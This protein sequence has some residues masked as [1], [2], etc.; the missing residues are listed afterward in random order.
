MDPVPVSL[1]SREVEVRGEVLAV[2][3]AAVSVDESAMVE[4]SAVLVENAKPNRPSVSAALDTFRVS[5]VSYSLSEE[6]EVAVSIR[7]DNIDS[8]EQST[9]LVRFSDLLQFSRTLRDKMTEHFSITAGSDT[10]IGGVRNNRL[11]R[12]EGSFRVVQQI[13]TAELGSRI[14]E[15]AFWSQS[16]A[17]MNEYLTH[18]VDLDPS[19]TLF[20]EVRDFLDMGEA[21][22]HSVGCAQRLLRPAC[23]LI[24]HPFVCCWA[25]WTN[26]QQSTMGAGAGRR[27]GY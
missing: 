23:C 21:T 17:A 25:W 7:I 18:I 15:P 20:P 2:A 22:Y 24:L 1:A 5:V 10:E 19:I 4:A 12:L 9:R 8:G 14:H 16:K 27:A 3:P 26:C 13:D 11:R 6:G